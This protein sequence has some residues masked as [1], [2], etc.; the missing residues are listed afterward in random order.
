MIAPT[1]TGSVEQYLLEGQHAEKLALLEYFENTL[2]GA[3]DVEAK[4]EINI[5]EIYETDMNRGL[6]ALFENIKYHGK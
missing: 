5:E 6:D 1:I 4:G 2:I 3:S